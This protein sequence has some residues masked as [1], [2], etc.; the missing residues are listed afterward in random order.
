MS[1]IP[2]PFPGSHLVLA[3][4]ILYT[5]I[6]LF[7]K[8]WA[9]SID[10]YERGNRFRLISVAKLEIS[11]FVLNIFVYHQLMKWFQDD[12]KQYGKFGATARR[13]TK[14]RASISLIIFLFL[15]H[16]L[17][18]M[19]YAPTWMQWLFF[20]LTSIACGLWTNVMAFVC[21]FF[22]VNLLITPFQ[23]FKPTAC[24]IALF[25]KVN[26][27]KKLLFDR[28]EQIKFTFGFSIVLSL[29]MWYGADKIVIKE[30]EFRIGNFTGDRELRFAVVSDI[31]AG[32]SVYIE[33]V[34]RV[35]EALLSLKLDAVFIVGD[36]VD[37]E[38]KDIGKRVSPMFTV[39]QR[40]PTYFVTGNHDYYIG[41]VQ[42]WLDLYKK[43]GIRVL[44]NEA[45][46]IH[47]ICL[48]GATDI[49]SHKAGI[50]SQE[51]NISLALSHCPPA[52]KATRVLL[53]HN[54]ASVREI[55]ASDLKTIDLVLS[56]H[57][58][59]GQFYVVFP[60]VY[61]ILPYF[62]GVYDLPHPS[63]GKL[64]ITAGSLYQGPPMKMLQMSEI[65][66]VTLKN[67]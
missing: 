15:A 58:H 38:V 8:S 23:N 57:T 27:F 32:A 60:A 63:T 24:L 5:L 4:I 21:G 46:M 55:A 42:E 19:Y 10:G 20:D 59:A 53:A 48:A 29:L 22:L 39:A 45:T 25:S 67:V 51:M 41:N 1:A 54:P 47:N 2:S 35:A 43:N 64:M 3:S 12:Q 30:R 11:M 40:F 18:F 31:H 13:K 62:Y 34:N 50:V 56:G 9:L 49:A 66:V 44:S 33:Q 65:W 36:M 37:G 16:A 28:K 6:H 61:W 7:A 26:Y 14:Q 52:G 17:Y